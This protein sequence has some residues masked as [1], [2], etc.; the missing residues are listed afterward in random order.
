LKMAKARKALDWESQIELS[1]DPVKAGCIRSQRN[2]DGQKTCTMCGE[3][4][5]YRIVSKHLGTTGKIAA[6]VS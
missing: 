6:I 2:N 5:A 3:Y 4:C 1:I